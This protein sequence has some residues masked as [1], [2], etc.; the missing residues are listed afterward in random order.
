MNACAKYLCV[1]LL[2]GVACAA[3]A[4]VI[5]HPGNGFT[6][7]F[8][9]GDVNWPSGFKP[10]GHAG[11]PLNFSL[12]S[13]GQHRGDH[14]MTPPPWL[15]LGQDFG[16]RWIPTIPH[17]QPEAEDYPPAAVWEPSA[18]Q[19]MVVGFAMLILV[20]LRQARLNRLQD[21]LA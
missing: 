17:G 7:A 1:L 4:L 14:L 5:H 18:G 6:P 19:L 9:G 16:S 20:R 12:F 11:L 13:G 15:V 3:N 21:S 10:G 2:S 8:H